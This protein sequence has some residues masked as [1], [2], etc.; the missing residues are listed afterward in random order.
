[1]SFWTLFFALLFMYLFGWFVGVISERIRQ[2]RKE[3]NNG[4][5]QK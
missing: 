4:K 3:N 5:V 2:S 1:M